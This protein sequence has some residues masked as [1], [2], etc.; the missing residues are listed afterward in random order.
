MPASLELTSNL[1]RVEPPRATNDWLCVDRHGVTPLLDLSQK[2]EVA[3][4]QRLQHYMGGE[5]WTA[6]GTEVLQDDLVRCLPVSPRVHWP[7]RRV[8]YSTSEVIQSLMWVPRA[9]LGEKE[10]LDSGIIYVQRH[11]ECLFQSSLVY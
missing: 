11:H 5:S 6:A 1:A 4:L 10:I 3:N 9:V 7:P 8:R 2:V